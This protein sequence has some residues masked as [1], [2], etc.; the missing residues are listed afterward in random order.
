MSYTSAQSESAAA[1]PPPIGGAGSALPHSWG[2]AAL[3]ANQVAVEVP[4]STIVQ[5]PGSPELK[6]SVKDMPPSVVNE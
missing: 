4:P 2:S 5:V 6:S 3:S 1:H